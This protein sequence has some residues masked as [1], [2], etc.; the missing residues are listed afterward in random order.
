MKEDPTPKDRPA[1]ETDKADLPPSYEQ[2]EDSSSEIPL[3]DLKKDLGSSHTTTVSVDHCIVH[4]KFL[5]AIADLRDTVANIDTLFKIND[6]QAE[7]FKTQED[8]CRALARIKEKRWAVYVARAVDR[9][10]TWWN[11]CV[12]T[13]SHLPTVTELHDPQKNSMKCDSKMGFQNAM[14]PL[15]VMMVWHA[16]ML[17]PRA[18]LEDCIRSAK[19]PLYMTGFPWE[20]INSCIDNKNFN[21]V[22]GDAS[23]EFFE[24]RTG[25][26]WDNLHDSMTKSLNCPRCQKMLPVPWTSGSMS[27]KLDAAF[28]SCSGYSD[29]NFSFDCPHCGLCIKHD[30][31]KVAKF[32]KDA[33]ELIHNDR[34][35]PGTIYNPKGIPKPKPLCEQFFPNYLI[36]AVSQ[37]L[38]RYTDLRLNG[39]VTMMRLRDLIESKIRDRNVRQL[40][41]QKPRR[42]LRGEGIAV[43]RMMSRYWDNSSPFALDLV[44]AVIRQGTFVQKMDNLDWIRSPALVA[45]M[46]RLIQK[47]R[48]F[49]DIMATNPRCMAVPTLDVDLAWHT[50]QLSP[51]RY[52]DFSSARTSGTFIDHDDKVEEN[53]LSEAF[54]WTSLMYKKVTNG[55][56]YSE[57]TC[58]YCEATRERTLRGTGIFPSSSTSRARTAAANLHSDPM[59]SPDPNKNPHI[60]AH[61]A[62]RPDGRVT[63]RARLLERQ[64]KA[65]YD[66]ALRRANKRAGRPIKDIPSGKSFDNSAY[67]YPMV[68]GYPFFFIPFYAPYMCD[69]GICSDAYACNPSCMTTAVGAFGNCVGGTCGAAVAAGSCAGATGGCGKVP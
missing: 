51:Q 5:A 55:Q 11:H 69:P 33:E 38:L 61:N 52:F 59:I 10:I 56:I 12:E 19:L 7:V 34:P 28:E 36:L 57:C 32:R 17:N 37:E 25:R 30:I 49:F 15:D 45:T 18:F 13:D 48:I 43:R 67:Y 24:S 44:G 14:P 65:N 60:S 47:Y 68:W 50:H 16:H 8:Q 66:K 63:D 22:P 3:L 1:E 64:L 40:V 20:A 9:Y 6:S 21:Y 35:M 31:L 4:L 41:H 23:R 54:E 46:D 62:V 39:T 2:V 58:W 42:L 27:L 29:N 26:S 53:V